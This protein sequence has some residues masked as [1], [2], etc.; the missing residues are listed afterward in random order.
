V[1]PY[2]SPVLFSEDPDRLRRER[3]PVRRR[4][5]RRH[6][7]GEVVDDDRVAAPPVVDDANE[8][9]PHRRGVLGVAVVPL[10]DPLAFEPPDAD[11]GFSALMVSFVAELIRRELGRDAAVEAVCA[12]GK[13]TSSCPG[14]SGCRAPSARRAPRC[15]SRS[16]SSASDG[17]TW[18]AP[19]LTRTHMTHS[20]GNRGAREG[21]AGMAASIA[22][23]GERAKSSTVAAGEGGCAFLRGRCCWVGAG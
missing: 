2:S 4:A 18:A 21:T 22:D 1:R 17:E 20:R 10:E 11:R 16:S 23:C 3:V 9:M 15:R 12:T 13:R 14:S 6:E 19:P 8:V 5:R 7:A